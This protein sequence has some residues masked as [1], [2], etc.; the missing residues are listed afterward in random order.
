MPY[1]FVTYL[2][3]YSCKNPCKVKLII[4]IYLGY[5]FLTDIQFT[6]QFMS[7]NARLFCCECSCFI[8]YFFHSNSYLFTP[9]FPFWWSSTKPNCSNFLIRSL[10]TGLGD[11]SFWML[12][13]TSIAILVHFFTYIPIFNTKNM[14][15]CWIRHFEWHFQ[16]DIELTQNKFLSYMLSL[17]AFIAPSGETL[18]SFFPLYI[19]RKKD[20]RL[21]CS[22]L[23]TATRIPATCAG[24]IYLS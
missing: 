4:S 24:I 23:K 5:S 20:S 9:A 15:F 10:I 11:F 2:I 1:A 3:I 17:L 14:I 13:I 22:V 18:K 7:G 6:P 19:R 12:H 16:N 21:L 8:N